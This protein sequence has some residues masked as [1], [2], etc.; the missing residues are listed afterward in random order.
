ME[1]SDRPLTDSPAGFVPPHPGS[2]QM[3]RWDGGELPTAPI[4]TGRNLAMML[5]PGLVLGA[6]AIG[7][8]E[9]LTGP[10]VTARF[11]GSLLWL[12]TLSILGQVIYN[13]EI[14]RYA[15]YSGEP[16]F[17]G[18]FRTFPGP[19][20][21]VFVY[22]LLDLGSVLPYLASNA[23]VPAAA[24]LLKRIPDPSS[25][26][27]TWNLLGTGLTDRGLLKVLSC[28]IFAS[29]FIPLSVGGKVYNSM[30]VVMTFKLITVM[31]FLAFLAIFFSSWDTWT[32]IFSGFVKFG[33]VPVIPPEAGGKA[34][35]NVFLAAREGRINS[36]F[37]GTGP[38]VFDL[39][40]VGILA[41]MAAISGNGGLTNTPISNYT[42]DQGWG[43]GRHVGA[44]PSIVGGHA[45]K[46]SHVGMVFPVNA[47]SLHRWKGWM[48]HVAREQWYLWM[49]A[50]FLGIALPSMLSVQFLPRG[51]VLTN[52]WLAAGMTADGVSEAVGGKLGSG[53]G[54]TFWYLTLFCGLLVLGTSM[55][56]TADGVLRRWVDVFW[57]AVP[58][59]RKWDTRH[60]GR[61]YFGVLCVYLVFGFIMLT[62]VPG[63]RLLVIG[64]GIL[65][66][67]A[68]G[69]SCFHVVVIN[70]ILLPK[71]LRPGWGR[72]ICLVLA[73]VFFS[74]IAVI[75]TTQQ[76]PDLI[77]EF[78]ALQQAEV[79]K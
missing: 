14:S 71:E 34:I 70:S 12:C 47:E 44:I 58:W 21:W 62:V 19:M 10:L 13:I 78:K 15:L 45:I 56:S 33:N 22:L 42:R 73:G 4:F 1:P 26:A 5:G 61:L 20:V 36:L 28:I 41:S 66:N 9:W 57:T 49:P 65:Y 6:S 32:E 51:T 29:V 16:I 79:A 72:R 46:L 55:A 24:M 76:V 75:S 43:M 64:T 48:K 7:G 35:D 2:K 37:F 30:K 40:V 60:I 69:F 18:K 31:G 63:D 11:G 17:T 59:L 23:A 52:N 39:S 53:L 77:K 38:G 25:T 74:T 27:E 54:D 8:G 68:L 67:Y 50:C 3:P